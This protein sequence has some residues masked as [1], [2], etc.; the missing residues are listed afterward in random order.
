MDTTAVGFSCKKCPKQRTVLA[1]KR[2]KEDYVITHYGEG[3]GIPWKCVKMISPRL[4]FAV[5]KMQLCQLK[6]SL[7]SH[8]LQHI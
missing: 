2:V 3:L 6:F 7:G 4:I 5:S 1:S 8:V